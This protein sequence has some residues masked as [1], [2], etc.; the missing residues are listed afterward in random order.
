MALS[1]AAFAT[2]VGQL[3]AAQMKNGQ[4][5]RKHLCAISA[6]TKMV[7]GVTTVKMWPGCGQKR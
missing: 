2:G 5:T 7:A 6:M 1:L 3:C 4:K